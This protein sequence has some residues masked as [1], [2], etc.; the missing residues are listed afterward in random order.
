MFPSFDPVYFLD[1]AYGCAS[2]MGIMRC[3]GASISCCLWPRWVLTLVLV[4]SS[5]A[6]AAAQAASSRRIAVAG[7]PLRVFVSWLPDVVA[8]A[9]GSVSDVSCFCSSCRPRSYGGPK[10]G[11][12][13]ARSAP[14][15]GYVAAIG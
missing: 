7:F 10:L 8:L 1:L 5:A 4:I 11:R 15:P 13:V 14:R 2:R 9:G 3:S 6:C 12:R